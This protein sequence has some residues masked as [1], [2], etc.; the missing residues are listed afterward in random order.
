MASCGHPDVP[1]TPFVNWTGWD[2]R[3]ADLRDAY[4]RRIAELAL[5]HLLGDGEATPV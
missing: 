3:R 5:D 4:R 1:R 2:V